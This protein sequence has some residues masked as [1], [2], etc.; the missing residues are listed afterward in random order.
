M[1]F[2]DS[3]SYD[4]GSLGLAISLS[5]DIW[6]PSVDSK[7][8]AN[9]TFLLLSY[10]PYMSLDGDL[11][12]ALAVSPAAAPVKRTTVMVTT[13][14]KRLD[15][16]A[17]VGTDGGRDASTTTLPTT[18]AIQTQY[19][20]FAPTHGPVQHLLSAERGGKR[21]ARL[22]CCAHVFFCVT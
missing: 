18:I 21:T 1:G 11:R 8:S 19:T 15:V 14:D 2:A 17:S 4:I 10:F 9:P 13:G 12:I 20:T 22:T 16:L 5:Y 6:S 3:S 7:F